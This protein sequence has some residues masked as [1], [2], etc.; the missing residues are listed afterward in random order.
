MAEAHERSGVNSASSG[1]THL[2]RRHGRLHDS[3]ELGEGNLPVLVLVNGIAIDI[4]QEGVCCKDL[5]KGSV[6][7]PITFL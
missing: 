2:L 1:M 4:L 7:F 6:A 5:L 3:H